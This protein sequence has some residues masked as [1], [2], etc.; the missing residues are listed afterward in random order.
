MET[1]FTMKHCNK[2]SE[3]PRYIRVRLIRVF[4]L[5]T[6]S[7]AAKGIQ[8]RKAECETLCS[9]SSS[10]CRQNVR[11]YFRFVY[12]P[13]QNK[14]ISVFSKFNK[15]LSFILKTQTIKTYKNVAKLFGCTQ[16]PSLQT[17]LKGV[18]FLTCIEAMEE[19]AS[20]FT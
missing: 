20:Q 15:G 1:I 14:T 2:N 3:T 10:L 19:K 4:C 13:H 6:Y 17:Y 11:T 18:R 8:C 16:N 7:S 5:Q 12:F 9:I